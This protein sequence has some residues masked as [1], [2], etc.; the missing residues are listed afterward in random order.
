MPFL[1]L[2]RLRTGQC[3]ASL[4]IHK[5]LRLWSGWAAE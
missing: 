2:L 1:Y 5:G 3:K 4:S